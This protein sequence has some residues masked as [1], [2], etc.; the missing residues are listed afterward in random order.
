MNS[1][2]KHFV[3]DKNIPQ[4]AA[5]TVWA[6]VAPRGSTDS[7][8]G[9]YLSDCGPILPNAAGQDNDKTLRKKLWEVTEKQLDEAV[10]KAGL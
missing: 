8:R 6:C 3:Q 2:L 9:A 1:I 4:G 10:A 7:M 5:T